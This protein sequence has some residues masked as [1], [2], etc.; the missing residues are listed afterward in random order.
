LKLNP[1]NIK[2]ALITGRP[3]PAI[4]SLYFGGIDFFS[5]T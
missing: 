5:G 3:I 2:Y 1:D 4:I